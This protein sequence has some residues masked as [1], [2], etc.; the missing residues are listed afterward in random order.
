MK[1][2]IHI[3]VILKIKPILIVN[4]EMSM[5]I[6][7]RVQDLIQNHAVPDQNHVIHDQDHVIHE[8]VVHHP[9]QD[10]KN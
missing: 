8:V 3:I 2:M 7:V 9:T 1:I 4:M 10:L 6:E 5:T